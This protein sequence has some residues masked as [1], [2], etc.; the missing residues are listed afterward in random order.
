MRKHPETTKATRAALIEAF[1]LI[2]GSRPVDKITVQEIAKKAG[3]NRCTFYQYFKDVYEL[4]E[5]I[6][7]IVISQVRENFEKNIVRENF[8]RTFFDAFTRI[9]Q[10]QAAYFTILLSPVHYSHFT[11]KLIAVVQPVFME[12]FCL[13][14]ENPADEYLCCIYFSTVLTAISHWIRSGRTIPLENL[15]RLLG[16]VLTRGVLTEIGFVT[17]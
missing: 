6:E 14:V 2:A 17:R 15:S 11:E 9:Q 1:C 4:L 3:Y 7:D 13:S 10:E 12:R 16:N 5:Y 8:I